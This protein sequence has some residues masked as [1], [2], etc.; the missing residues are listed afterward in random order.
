MPNVV[1]QIPAHHIPVDRWLAREYSRLGSPEFLS[2]VA[3][4]SRVLPNL[5]SDSES[6]SKE[7]R[8]ELPCT[9]WEPLAIRP[10]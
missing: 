5:N 6:L 1:L 9:P 2:S 3:S 4:V 10:L 7:A 8:E